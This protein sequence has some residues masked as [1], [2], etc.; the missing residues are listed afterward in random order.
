VAIFAARPVRFS[1][2]R[3]RRVR[4]VGLPRQRPMGIV[5][6]VPFTHA[7]L[8]NGLAAFKSGFRRHFRSPFR[9]RESSFG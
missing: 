8:G 1:W 3:V 6:Q 4:V 9:G 7:F 2:S 5:A